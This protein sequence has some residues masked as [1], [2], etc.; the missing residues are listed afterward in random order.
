VTVLRVD[1]VALRV[2][3]LAD[4]K[5]RVD[6]VAMRVVNVPTPKLRVDQVALRVV[7]TVASDTTP[8]TATIVV[9]DSSLIIGET[10][11]VTITFS[12]AVTGFTN[13]DLTVVNGTLS[14][15]SSSDG[16]VTWTATFT[17]TASITDSTNVITL[18]NSG[19]TDLAGNAGTGTTTSNNYAIDTVV[20]TGRMGVARDGVRRAT[21]SALRNAIRQ[22]LGLPAGPPAGAMLMEDGTAMLME[23]GSYMLTE[24][25][26]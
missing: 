8:P 13:A 7:S 15:V 11:L 19:V 4:P 26:G 6:Q 24:S 9:A 21:R 10:S 16:G 1:Q 3:N 5:L 22:A 23:D 18:A 2:V 25:G 17:P 12:E 14:T 20:T